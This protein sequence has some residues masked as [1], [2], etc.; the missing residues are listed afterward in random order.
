MSLDEKIAQTK[1]LQKKGEF[2]DAAQEA[3]I[4]T[5]GDQPTEYAKS[6][7]LVVDKLFDP[8]DEDDKQLMSSIPKN[9]LPN[10]MMLVG[11]ENAIREL[12]KG[13]VELVH[14]DG[15]KITLYRYGDN[16]QTIDE[17]GKPSTGLIKF[18]TV[19]TK[20]YAQGQF[21]AN[22]WHGFV[23]GLFMQLPAV[24]GKSREQGVA[25]V[26]AITNSDRAL[27]EAQNNAQTGLFKKI[28]KGTFG[29]L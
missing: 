16:Q 3:G 22:Y 15:K 23:G 29:R 13:D 25:V 5:G 19:S 12:Y 28:W 10:T 18:R 27:I 9:I 24:E 6:A 2:L 14:K 1:L 20:G 8:Y 17:E 21:W 4:H 7:K 11:I 26:S